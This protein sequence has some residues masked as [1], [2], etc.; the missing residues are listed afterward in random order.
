MPDAYILIGGNLGDIRGNLRNSIERI[1]GEGIKITDMS[2]I[3][4]TEPWGFDHDS[5]F[6]NQVIRIETFLEPLELLEKIQKIERDMGRD[7][8][9]T[10][11]SARIIDIDILFYE[12]RIIKTDRLIIPHPKIHERMFVLAPMAEIAPE[13]IHPELKKPI[14]MLKDECIDKKGIRKLI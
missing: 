7:K 9:S 3:Y 11:Y 12:N 5:D 4:E 14:S 8:S 10:S 6:L 2:S 13:F 1:S